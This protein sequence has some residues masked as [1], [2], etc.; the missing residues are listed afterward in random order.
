MTDPSSPQPMSQEEIDEAI[1]AGAGQI[2]EGLDIEWASIEDVDDAV[3]ND[4]ERA[5]D[6]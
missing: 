5:L 6:N 1:R 4:L 3:L 2:P